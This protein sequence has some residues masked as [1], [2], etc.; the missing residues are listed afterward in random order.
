MVDED[1]CSI[2]N[3]VEYLQERGVLAKIRREE[4]FTDTEIEISEKQIREL[5]VYGDDKLAFL[6]SS[7]VV[8]PGRNKLIVDKI[9]QLHDEGKAVLVFACS[10]EHCVILQTLLQGMGRRAA[11][12]L[13]TTSLKERVNAIEE[14]KRGELKILINYGVLTTGF[15]APN[16]DALL[17]ARPTTSVVLYSQMVGRALRG[18]LNGGH[19]E[20]LLIDVRDNFVW[21]QMSDLFNFYNIYWK[22][23]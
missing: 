3:P 19:D 15:D 8:N 16:L 12:I 5:K 20:N 21:G 2:Q 4:L 1:G 11:S 9:V 7:L 10:A 14:F 17:I 6:L 13:A 23:Y 18:R 22:N